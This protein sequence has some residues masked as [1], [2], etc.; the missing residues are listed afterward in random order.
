MGLELL[1]E[2]SPVQAATTPK[3]EPQ[4]RPLNRVATPG[5]RPEV[6]RETWGATANGPVVE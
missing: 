5:P 2:V 6:P 4:G 1:D 3:I